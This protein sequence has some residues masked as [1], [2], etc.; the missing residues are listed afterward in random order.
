MRRTAVRSS[1]LVR[2]FHFSLSEEWQLYHSLGLGPL[3]LVLK[4]NAYTDVKPMFAKERKPILSSH[5][6]FGSCP[7]KKLWLDG[8]LDQIRLYLDLV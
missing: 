7:L 5:Y 8:F 1:S 3:L 4:T 6:P 2:A